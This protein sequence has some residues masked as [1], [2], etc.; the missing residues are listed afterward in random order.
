MKKAAVIPAVLLAM[1]CTLTGCKK[2]EVEKVIA[3]LV[4]DEQT[5]ESAEEAQEES[6]PVIPEIDTSVKI[7]A[8]ARV[9]VVSKCV[10]GEFWSL[11][12]QGMEQAVEDVNE[13]YGFEKD[14]KVTMTFEGA[15][16]E[17]DVASQVNTLDAVIAENPDVLCVS[18]SDMDSLQ[19]Q[20]E[21]AK[22]NGIPV[23]AFD[24]GVSD[25]K[26]IRAF[27]GTDNTRV[28]EIAAYR[29]AVAIGKM[30]KVAV[31]SA[32][33]KTQSIQERVAGFT[34][35]IANYPDIEVV[36]IVYQDQVEDMTAAMQEVLDKNPQLEGVFC[37]NADVSD[38]YL[39]MKKDETKDPVVMVGVDATAK[40]QEAIRNN[41]EVGVVSQQPYAM[42][43]Q[44][45]WTALMATAP[46]KK[47]EITRDVRIDPAWI[48]ASVIDDPAYSAYLYAN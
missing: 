27:R 33:E 9:A 44:T 31:F 37:T 48:D 26:M 4:S 20:L 19:A 42:G 10:S 17:K 34:S 29:L 1:L 38:L 21:A 41:K 22:E 36:D 15:S 24:S 12:K 7:Q 46:K 32:Q 5:A 47:V 2:E 25:S 40:Q 3:P 6:D 45:L 39:D 11:V 35:Y 30:G 28:G 23:V 8:G 14:D 18:A 16:D 43:Y 13:A